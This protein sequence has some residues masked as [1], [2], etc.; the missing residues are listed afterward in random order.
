MYFLKTMVDTDMKKEQ[1][2]DSQF[3]NKMDIIKE[4]YITVTPK[5]KIEILDRVS[6]E[7]YT[8][9]TNDFAGIGSPKDLEP[10]WEV[11]AKIE[12]EEKYVRFN[13]WFKKHGGRCPSW[14][15]PVAFGE[16]GHLIGVCAR[17]EIQF[18]ESSVYVPVRITI[19]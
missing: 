7:L 19:N 2:E 13:N 6:Q 16:K 1:S 14:R 5:K 10:N 11:T 4:R 15:Y 18:N 12:K 3:W 17:K 8:R 9:L